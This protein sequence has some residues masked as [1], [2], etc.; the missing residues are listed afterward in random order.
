[1][2]NLADLKLSYNGGLGGNTGMWAA[3]LQRMMHL[4]S[5]DLSSCGINEQ[6]LS[7]IASSVGKMPN[8]ANLGL[9]LTWRLV[10]KAGTWAASLQRMMHLKSLD[11]SSCGINEQDLSHIAS[12]VGKMPNLADINLSWNEG[13]GGH[14]GTWAACLQKMIHLKSLKL[15]QC[16]INAQDIPH[17]ASSVG[18]MPNVA[19]LN[20]SQ[21]SKL[22]GNA[23]TWAVS[24]L[25]MVHLKKLDMQNFRINSRDLKYIAESVS[26][27]R[28][29]V[30]CDFSS[31]SEVWRVQ[32][33]V[34]GIELS[35][36]RFS[37]TIKDMTDVLQSFT[38][39]R[40]LV[41][42][43]IDGVRGMGGSASIWIPLLQNLTDLQELELSDCSLHCTDVEHLAAALSQMQ[44]LADLNLS[45]I[46]TWVVTP[47]SIWIPLLQNLKEL[48]KLE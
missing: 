36:K 19:N 38:N 23:G 39:R 1:M 15:L 11:L 24:L 34:N 31:D 28:N 8:L 16:D 45:E 32:S 43:T 17:I 48:Q 30:D 5:L 25:S 2:P 21:N 14:A 42:L 46:R 29:L 35:I 9:F 13:L 7:Q 22:G 26:R 6:D 20:L 10:G 44:N 18:K 33:G 3:S 37:L 41:R 27:M 47:E 12:S 4:K 40:D